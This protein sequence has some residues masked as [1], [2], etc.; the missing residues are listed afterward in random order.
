MAMAK[1]TDPVAL[2]RI[3]RIARQALERHEATQTTATV[4]ASRPQADGD[5]DPQRAAS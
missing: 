2:A 4:A 3:A 5:A 1:L